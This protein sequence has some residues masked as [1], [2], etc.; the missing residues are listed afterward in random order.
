MFAALKSY[1]SL[2]QYCQSC[3]SLLEGAVSNLTG[4]PG[5][6][7]IAEVVASAIHKYFDTAMAHFT[8]VLTDTTEQLQQSLSPSK[9]GNDM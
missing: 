3:E 5:N 2:H 8:K 7:S 9:T 1:E 4:K 6:S